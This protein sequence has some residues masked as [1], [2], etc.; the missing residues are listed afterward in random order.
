MSGMFMTFNPSGKSLY[1]L[2]DTDLC[3]L[4]AYQTFTAQVTT[5]LHMHFGALSLIR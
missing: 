4:V 5:L 1:H 2:L 3:V